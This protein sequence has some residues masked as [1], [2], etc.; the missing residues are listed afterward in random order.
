LKK[1][2]HVNSDIEA[3]LDEVHKVYKKEILRISD[4]FLKEISELKQDKRNALESVAKIE[5]DLVA[6]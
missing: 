2:E 1:I 5:R 3:K 4:S 6:K